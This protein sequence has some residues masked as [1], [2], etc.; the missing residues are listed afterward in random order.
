MFKNLSTEA[1]GVTGHQSEIIE[2]A[3]SFGFEGI[4]LNMADFAEQ[5]AN[6]G[7]PH[8]KRLID[9][10]QIRVGLFQLPV[11]WSG[12]EDRFRQG[13]EKLPA[14][15]ET[16]AGLDCRRCVT[17]VQPANDDRPYHEN[18][19]F[20][21][22]RLGQIAD[23]LSPHGIHLGLNFVATAAAREGRAF[24]FIHTLDAL[25]QMAKN[26]G[27]ENVG[28]VADLWPIHVA[29][30]SLDVAKPL[31]PERIVAVY[32]SD[33]PADVDLEK[34]D[35]R[36]R[37]MPGETG[38]IDAAGAVATL[39][40][41]GFD[42]PLIARCHRASL[43]DKR[44]DAIVRLAGERLDRIVKGEQEAEESDSL[45]PSASATE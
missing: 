38:A 14:I 4:E 35:D 29:G 43:K 41:W 16:A 8:A 45:E 31:A 12:D 40:E 15:A 23:V 21:R 10:A 7:L 17:T 28:V 32:L 9:S 19:E 26:V 5:A 20:H 44:R 22:D 36:A 2:L 30:E 6:Y 24:E 11:T 13:M 1:L 37:L 25:V 33:A 18:F 42:G 27:R 3:L 34:I 39:T